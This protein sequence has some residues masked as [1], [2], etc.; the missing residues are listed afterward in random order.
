MPI[1][2]LAAFYQKYYQPDNAMLII[3]GKFDEAKALALVAKLFGAIPKPTRMLEKTYT[4]EPTQDGERSVT[5]RRVGDGQASIAIYHIPAGIAPRDRR[6]RSARRR[7]GRHAVRP[8]LQGAGGK[9]EGRRR[10]MEMEEL[11]D[12]GFLMAS[13]RLQAGPVARRRRQILLKTIEASSPNRPA[14]KKWSASRRAC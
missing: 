9:Q 8:S 12:P 4:V 13:A 2:S 5:L 10:S 11:H 7:P 3:A 1:D 14:R 6:A